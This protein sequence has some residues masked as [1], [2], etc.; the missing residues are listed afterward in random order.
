MMTSHR[1]DEMFQWVRAS[2]LLKNNIPTKYPTHC[3]DLKHTEKEDANSITGVVIKQL[4]DVH[5]TLE[6]TKC[7][8]KITI[9]CIYLFILYFVLYSDLSDH[10]ELREEA[11]K[12]EKK[13]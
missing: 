12:A 6:G 1:V 11:Y 4:E 13:K 3:D 5:P 8:F 10:D 7:L 2:V 9:F